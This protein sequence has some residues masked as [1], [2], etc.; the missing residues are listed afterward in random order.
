[1]N[2]RGSHV[3]VIIS[4]IIFVTFIIFLFASVKAPITRDETKKN[5]FDGV[6]S[7]IKNRISADMTTITVN[8]SSGGACVGLNNLLNEFNI[9]GD[10]VVQDYSG[11]NIPSFI[12][13][14]SLNINRVSTSDTFFKIYH[15]Q[16]F[17][18]LETGSACSQGT[19]ELGPTKT[20]K[21]VFENRLI[22]L[23]NEDPQ[24]VRNELNV[25][26]GV[27]FT[28]G[29]ILSN[30]TTIEKSQKEISTNVYVRESPIE[31]V[32]LEGKINEGYLKTTVW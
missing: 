5:I 32:D 6:E 8:I 13:G 20:E 31:Y 30:G 4:F 1:M 26:N 21:Y 11:N 2:K 16:E 19:Y 22:G 3:E 10:I 29:I 23:I 7:S 15:S 18:G 9:N 28:Y 25:P 17:S 24:T 12:S 14:N 27:N